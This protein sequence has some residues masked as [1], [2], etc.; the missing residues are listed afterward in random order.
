MSNKRVVITGLG[1]VCGL[2]SNAAEIWNAMKAGKDGVTPLERQDMLPL[3]VHAAGQVASIPEL[4][5]EPKTMAAV[6]RFAHLAMAAAMEAWSHAGLSK[7]PENAGRMGAI[8]GTAIAGNEAI[9]Q[10]YKMLF[11]DQK[12]RTNVFAVPRIMPGAP[13]GQISMMLGL[14]GPVMGVTSAC[15][16]ANHAFLVALDQIRMG[17]ADLVLAGGTE[18]PLTY[19]SLRAWESLRI[20]SRDKCRPFSANR[21]GLVLGEGAGAVVLESLDHARN[22]GANILAELAGAGI[23][24]D[25]GDIVA[26]TLEGP[27]Q[28]VR[29][30]L[31]DAQL[32][33]QAVDYVSAHG[34]A[35]QANDKTE[36]QVIK[37]VFEEHA[38]RLAISSTKS[39]HAHCLGGSAA[40]ELIACVGA[41]RDQII[42]PTINLNAPDPECDLD[43]TP[44]DAQQRAVS[45]AISNAFAFGGTNAVIAIKKFEE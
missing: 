15:S 25:A 30:C 45:V 13:A 24:A 39:M 28:A 27:A 34:T 41:I 14:K 33:P 9:E 6:D 42:P 26:P 40:L 7:S 11:I 29:A 37:H 23:S 3:K 19:G 10:G 1:G 20:L 4:G 44:N 31:D 2:G 32:E 35:T 36:T 12:K 18:A 16:S 8:I 43:Y 38:N 5:L 22:R 21:S 17:R